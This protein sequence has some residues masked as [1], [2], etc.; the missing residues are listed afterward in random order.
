MP[1]MPEKGAFGKR[2]AWETGEGICL[3]KQ[4]TNQPRDNKRPLN[5]LSSKVTEQANVQ[6]R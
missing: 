2:R 6:F 3:Q 4:L 1:Q 5:G